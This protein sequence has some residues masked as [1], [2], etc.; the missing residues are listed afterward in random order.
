V[1][2]KA[3]LQY[4]YRTGYWKYSPETKW[5]GR[6]TDHSAP[7]IAQVKYGWNCNFTVQQP[8]MS[9]TVTAV[10]RISADISHFTMLRV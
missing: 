1:T 3:I 5:L 8:F 6:E 4:L 2:G 10:P 7:F 9:C